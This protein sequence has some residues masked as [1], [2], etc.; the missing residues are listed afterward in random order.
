MLKFILQLTVGL[1][2][3]VVLAHVVGW[4]EVVF[5]NPIVFTILVSFIVLFAVKIAVRSAR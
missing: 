1:A 4:L 5:T 2:G 3:F